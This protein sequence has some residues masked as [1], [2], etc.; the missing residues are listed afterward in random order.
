MFVNDNLLVKEIGLIAPHIAI[1]LEALLFYIWEVRGSN[2]WWLPS[3]RPGKFEGVTKT[4]S[5]PLLS[6]FFII[7]Y[8]Y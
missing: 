3:V 7:H 1:E 6:K 4:R 8:Y 5:T 2:I